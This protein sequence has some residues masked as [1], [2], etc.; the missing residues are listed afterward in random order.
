VK[1]LDNDVVKLPRSDGAD[2]WV[3]RRWRPAPRVKSEPIRLLP[4]V[5]LIF[6]VFSILTAIMTYPVIFHMTDSI[7][8][9]FR[10]D[11]FHALW[12]MW[13]PAYALLVQ[14][15]SPMF[16]PD[17]YVPFGFDMIRNQDL[18]PA[19]CL[20]FIPLTYVLGDVLSYNIVTLLTFP[21]TALGTYLLA[22]D[23][24]G[25][26]AGAFLA[27]T[28]VGFCEYRYVRSTGHMTMLSTQWI[29]FFFLFL[30]R[31]IT[32]RTV[33]N[34]VLLGLMYSLSALE[35]W[36]Y[37]WLL[38]I[39]GPLYIL[40][41]ID[42]RRDWRS[43]F[44]LIRPGLA[45]AV[46]VAVLV[47]PWVGAYAQAT[48]SGAMVARPLQ[49]AQAF[50]ASAVDY[51]IPGVEHPIWGPLVQ[52]T[53]RAGPNGHWLSEWEV[54][55]GIVAVVLAVVGAFRLRD[56]RV[57]ALLVTAVGAYIVSLGP[58][59]YIIHPEMS[60]EAA[61]LAPLSAI[62]LPVYVLNSIPPFAF[63]R[64]WARMGFA[65]Q[66]VVGMLAA[67]GLMA[68]LELLRRRGI[69]DSPATTW[70]VTAVVAALVLF[71]SAAAPM[72]LSSTAPRPVEAWLAEQPPNQVFMEYPVP[73]HGYS[74]PAMYSTRQ[75]GQRIVMGYASYPPN[76]GYWGTLARFP[77]PETLDLLSQWGVS[78]ILVDETLYRA[79]D[80]FWGVRQ[81]WATL[82]PAI[83]QSSRLRE[84]TV[85]GGVHVYGLDVG[86]PSTASAATGAQL[87]QNPDFE[88]AV[89]TGP[90]GWE[91]V[92]SPVY[93]RSAGQAHGGISSVTVGTD[94][95][96]VSSAAS[97]QSGECY[98]LSVAMR[99]DEQGS[100]GRLQM[101]WLDANGAFMDAQ[102]A[103][104]RVVG[105]SPEWQ[106]P[107]VQLR[108]P[109]GAGGVRVYATAHQGHVTLDDFALRV[110]HDGC[111]PSLSA[112]PNP[113][114]AGSGTAATSISWDTA[115][116]GGGQVWVSQDGQPEQL[117]ADG[118][119]GSSQLQISS[120]STYELRLYAG[121][122]HREVL[123]TT[124]VRRGS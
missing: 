30:E 44:A 103:G 47:G 114:P 13:Y 42:W 11:N 89:S 109:T 73:S 107:R 100:V 24:W 36:T 1:T 55:L 84:L 108:A 79:G 119:Y 60:A 92:G 18:S 95:L 122:E 14:W 2:V 59:L 45:A 28:I 40:G 19:N 33:R 10:G 116:S 97:A 37:A 54:Y 51:L 9:A 98:E 6:V 78:Y 58:S 15:K 117:F 53:W 91:R 32:R 66:L 93:N 34:G 69:A 104:V 81:T 71:D 35:T 5:I 12:Q 113:V 62:K 41:R 52:R 49:E 26:R 25:N 64:G 27:A 16:D 57:V 72:G 121:R 85:R 65:V 23:F 21:L 99:S 56:R 76:L 39:V 50:S 80:E 77:A 70:G 110:A 46:V 120:G 22:R 3:D 86:G 61:N 29:P 82:Q 115:A 7:P 123:K 111:A 17:V 74:G 88:D 68:L 63:M 112:V 38:A 87:L 105:A 43:I 106:T 102:L 96:Y 75:T 94:D 124:T 8:G 48:T 90:V 31:T 20:L 83:E 118:P 4:E 67:G 101:N